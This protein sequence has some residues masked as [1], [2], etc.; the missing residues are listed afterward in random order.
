MKTIWNAV[1]ELKGNLED[2]EH[3]AVSSDAICSYIYVGTDENTRNKGALQVTDEVINNG[4]WA[5][6]SSFMEFNALVTEMSLGLDVNPVNEGYYHKYL[7]AD[8]DVLEPIKQKPVYTQEMYDNGELPSVGMEVSLEEDTEFFSCASGEVKQLKADD[9]VSVISV[10]KRL[11]N[12]YT[13]L[14]L[15]HVD[16]GFCVINPDYVKPIPPKVDLIN[17]EAYQYN[18]DNSTHNG[19]YDEFKKS[20]YSVHSITCIEYCTNIKPLTV[21]GE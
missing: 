7:D 2:C 18:C 16:A 6:V 13:V 14:T 5:L 1:N 11:D 10:G 4:R 15:M 8:K 19:I 3:Y 12:K 21:K 9:I 17:G 20:M